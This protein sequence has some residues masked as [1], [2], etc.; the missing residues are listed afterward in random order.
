MQ[1]LLREEYSLPLNQLQ[2]VP[3]RLK[4]TLRVELCWFIKWSRQQVSDTN[5]RIR[6]LTNTM[7]QGK[8]LFRNF[9]YQRRRVC[10][11]WY[12]IEKI[13]PRFNTRINYL[14]KKK[15]CI[16][17]LSLYCWYALKQKRDVKTKERK[18][19]YSICVMLI[20]L[21]INIKVIKKTSRT[22]ME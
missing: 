14:F 10:N 20:T 9:I 12:R 19:L 4:R 22:K 8:N 18:I 17:F 6:L 13:F 1:P 7:S 16:L 15:L 3:N 5:K 21:N 11:F 2:K